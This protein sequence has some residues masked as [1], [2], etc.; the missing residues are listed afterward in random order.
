MLLSDSVKEGIIEHTKREYPK[1]MCGV[2]VDSGVF[3]PIT[4]VAKS[5]ERDTEDSFVM[6]PVE[7]SKVE[8]S[9]K[10]IAIVH[11]HPDWTAKPSVYD[12]VRC[13]QGDLPWVVVS[14][15]EVDVSITHPEKET[16]LIG[17]EFV[18]GIQDCYT[19]V[20]DY[21][22]RVLGIELS[23]YEREDEWWEKGK[24]Y[25]L[26]NYE[27]EGFYQVDD[28]KIGDM[29]LM[30]IESNTTNHAAIMYD[31]NVILHHL[32]GR[33]SCLGIYGGYWRDRTTVVLRHKEAREYEKG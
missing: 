11:S 24:N 13:N 7:Y 8:D 14:Y 33:P 1:E 21:Y 27:K 6:C 19:I 5:F 20:Q 18:H 26:D 2:I 16:P 23:S 3:L 9:H 31:D 10:V 15:P 30:Q 32:Y 28:L 22:K 25:Y 12:K 17:R 29:I 4:N